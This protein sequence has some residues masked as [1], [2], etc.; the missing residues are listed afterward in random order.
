MTG[1]CFRAGTARVSFF[2]ILFVFLRYN[3]W[4]NR[5]LMQP[6]ELLLSVKLIL[7]DL[8]LQI[9]NVPPYFLLSLSLFLIVFLLNFPLLQHPFLFLLFPFSFHLSSSIQFNLVPFLKFLLDNLKV[10]FILMMKMSFSGR[11]PIDKHKSIFLILPFFWL[12]THFSPHF[13]IFYLLK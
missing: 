10:L 13:A 2:G 5:T 4:G 11:F 8:L 9:I 7:A 1:E 6:I 3:C 12:F